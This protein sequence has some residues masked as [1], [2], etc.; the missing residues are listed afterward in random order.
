[1]AMDSENKRRG[2][3]TFRFWPLFPLLPTADSTVDQGDR[4]M[5]VGV[6]PGILAAAAEP[7]IFIEG[8]SLIDNN[9]L[10]NS[11]LQNTLEG[12]S[13]VQNTIAGDSLL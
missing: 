12:N 8:F 5:L 13:L 2:A 7:V 11:L 1:M 9:V 6:Y 4:Q 3:L 10:G